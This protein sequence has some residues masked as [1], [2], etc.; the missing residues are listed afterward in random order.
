MFMKLMRNKPPSHATLHCFRQKKG[1]YG[2]NL[3]RRMLTQKK[4]VPCGCRAVGRKVSRGGALAGEATP[5]GGISWSPCVPWGPWC[6]LLGTW[7]GNVHLIK[8]HPHGQ[9]IE[10]IGDCFGLH[11]NGSFM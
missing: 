7:G 10:L 9:M 11:K 5:R 3:H 4:A 2:A 6:E 8:K 1:G